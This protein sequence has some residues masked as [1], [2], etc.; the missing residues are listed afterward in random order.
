MLQSAS[1][2]LSFKLR[3]V[4]AQNAW[5]RTKSRGADIFRYPRSGKESSGIDLDA[6]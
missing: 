4:D 2:S 5:A 3:Q 6:S 1:L